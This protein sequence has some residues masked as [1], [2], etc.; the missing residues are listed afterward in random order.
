MSLNACYIGQ[1]LKKETGTTLPQYLNELRINHAKELL[2]TT[3]MGINEI[4]EACGYQDYFYF[5]K[6]FKKSTGK[7]PTAF[8]QAESK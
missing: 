8:R 1:L 6:K 5:I 2:L 7:T 4:G 3:N